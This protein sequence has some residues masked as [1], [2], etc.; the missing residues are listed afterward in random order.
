MSDERLVAAIQLALETVEFPQG[1]PGPQGPQGIPG[2]QG[3]SAEIPDVL[4]VR[5]LNITDEN[6]DSVLTLIERNGTPFIW[7]EDPRNSGNNGII[8]NNGRFLILLNTDRK[9]V[10]EGTEVCVGGGRIRI[11]PEN[12]R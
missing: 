10:G 7:L 8:F 5:E 12:P 4:S 11:C 3:D 9:S 1:P 2:K 6:G